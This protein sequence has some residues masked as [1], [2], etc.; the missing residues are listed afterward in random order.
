EART[1]RMRWRYSTRGSVV[2][3]AAIVPHLG[4][5]KAGAASGEFD[6]IVPSDDDVLHRIAGHSGRGLW[7]FS[8]GPFLW[9]YRGLGE[10]IWESPAAVRIGNVEMLIVPFYDGRV[11]GYRLDRRDEWL[12][13]LSS[14]AYGRTMLARIAASMIATLALGLIFVWQRRRSAAASESLTSLHRSI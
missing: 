4:N 10:T 12:P 11:H 1:G 13:Q 5:T 9:A 7:Q 3:S 14:P 2:A 6:V 8:P